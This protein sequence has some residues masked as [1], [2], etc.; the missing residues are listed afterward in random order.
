MVEQNKSN[1][2]TSRRGRNLR[3]AARI[4]GLVAV[5]FIMF[6]LVGESVTSWQEEGF[7]FSLESLYV[8]VPSVILLAA[9]IMAW[10]KERLGGISLVAG[11]LLLSLSPSV[12]SI[13]YGGAGF[14]FY[15]GMFLFALPF[16][17]SGV[18]FILASIRS[19]EASS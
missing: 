11:Y 6:I 14:T 1:T 5:V 9:F 18:L 15:T 10:W 4:I 19:Q 12:H 17:L 13:F 3:W 16:L 8:I 7:S 2:R